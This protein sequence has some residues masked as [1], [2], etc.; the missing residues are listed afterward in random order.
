MVQKAVSFIPA[1]PHSQPGEGRE[2]LTGKMFGVIP[3]R[4]GSAWAKAGKLMK[5]SRHRLRRILIQRAK[6]LCTPWTV[7][8][9]SRAKR[10]SHGTAG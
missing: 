7:D 9:I 1:H 4:E 6:A 8:F 5:L 3:G 2:L 10:T